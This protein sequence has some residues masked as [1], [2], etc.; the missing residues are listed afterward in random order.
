MSP[1]LVAHRGGSRS[2]DDRRA[3]RTSTSEDFFEGTHRLN[4]AMKWNV[5]VPASSEG[6]TTTTVLIYDSRLENIG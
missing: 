4:T 6:V 5:N 3:E 1:P 2:G